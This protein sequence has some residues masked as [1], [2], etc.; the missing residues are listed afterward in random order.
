MPTLYVGSQA[1]APLGATIY[2]RR[3]AMRH[4]QAFP[5]GFR[6]IAGDASATT[7]Q[8][9]SVTFWNCG[10]QVV[11]SGRRATPPSCPDGRGSMLRLHVNFPSCWD[12]RNLDSENHKSHVAYPERGRCPIGYPCRVPAISL[13]YRYPTLGGPAATLASGGVYSGHARLLQRVEPERAAAARRLL[14]ERAAPLRAARLINLTPSGPGGAGRPAGPPA[15]RADA[16][17]HGTHTATAARRRGADSRSRRAAAPPGT[18]PAPARGWRTCC[19]GR[20]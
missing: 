11:E 18:A 14:P 9:L 10:A 7:A 12:G 13:I 19:A 2:Y 16:C 4:V 1:V 6:M 3:K 15:S 8:P 5:P 20:A 17:P